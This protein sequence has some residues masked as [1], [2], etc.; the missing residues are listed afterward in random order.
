[1][2]QRFLFRGALGA[3]V[4]LTGC[5]VGPDYK[6]PAA[7][8]VPVDWRW[9][10]AEPNDALAKGNWWELFHDPELNRLEDQAGAQN[11][12]LQEAVARVDE[13]RSRARLTGAAFF[14]SL[15]FDPSY[16]R[17][18]LPADDPQFSF[19]PIPGITSHQPRPYDSFSVPV[20]LSYEIDLWGRVRR[21][22]QS[23]QAQAQ[24]SVADYENVLLTLHSDVAVEYLTLCEYDLETQILQET[25]KQRTESLRIT[26]VRV[27]AGRATNLD[28]A[29]AQTDLTNAEAQLDGV[30]QSRAETLDA[31]AELCGTN[32]TDLNVPFRPLDIAPPVIP[33]GLPCSVLERRPD[34]AEAERTMAARNE[35]IGVAYAA[36]FPAVSLTGQGGVL[37]AHAMDLFHWQNTIWSYGPSI[38]LPIFQGGQNVSNLQVARAQY[39]QSV[40]AYRQSV[41]G[42]VKDV[43]DALADLKFLGR[44]KEALRQSVGSAKQATKL[45]FDRFRVGE[46]N[47]T[48]VIVST[49]TELNAE[50][51][52]A[53]VEGQQLYA[54][55][56]L[57][58]ALGGGWDAS[59]LEAG[60]A[61]AGAV[62]VAGEFV[63]AVKGGVGDFDGITD[64]TGWG[65]GGRWD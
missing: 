23:A 12:N 18:Q 16:S 58:K 29:Q 14:P 55:V 38:S 65:E 7:V 45:Q 36:F 64:L 10:P 34:V 42:A 25:V 27:E 59:M 26:K 11:Q 32:A 54:T 6:Q 24:A 15:K 19:V 47:Y 3:L 28:V 1:M 53:Q 30:Q 37:S 41:L 5:S 39:N 33:A 21:S 50:R 13:A 44:E 57:I 52:E 60:A 2:N 63:E 35:Q 51:S 20:D 48:D 61:G 62:W 8:G 56:R 31:L 43:E 46:T 4:L 22:F 49:D 40:A 9:K 17:T